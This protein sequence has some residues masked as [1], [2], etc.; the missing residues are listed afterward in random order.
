M[1]R[2]DDIP[3]LDTY[4]EN[5]T[6]PQVDRRMDASLRDTGRTRIFLCAKSV[7]DLKDWVP[8]R[9][10]EVLTWL[11]RERNAEI[12]FCDSPGNAVYYAAILAGVPAEQRHHCHDWS[13]QLN[14]AEAGSL[15]RRMDL[16]F[17]IDTGF[18]HIAASYHVPVVGLYRSR[19]NRG[20]GTRGTRNTPRCDRRTCP[21]RGR[22]SDSTSPRCKPHLNLIYLLESDAMRIL[23]SMLVGACLQATSDRQSPASRLLQDEP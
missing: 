7:Y 20:A 18:L 1:L 9:F 15:L 21:A 5:W 16:A 23:V 6:N 17:G 12:H 14:I 4:N 19:S 2:A 3:V 13:N 8:D 22:C 10:A 11:V